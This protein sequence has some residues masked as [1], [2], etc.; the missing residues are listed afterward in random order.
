MMF[1]SLFPQHTCSLCSQQSVIQVRVIQFN[2]PG[3]LKL[4]PS[5]FVSSDYFEDEWNFYGKGKKL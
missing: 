3:V 2:I 5:C 4:C 1:Q